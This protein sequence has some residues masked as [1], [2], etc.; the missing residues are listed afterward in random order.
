MEFLNINYNIY[1][2]RTGIPR[3]IMTGYTRSTGILV[4]LA[5]LARRITR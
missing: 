2:T 3:Y 4:S 1:F 5:I